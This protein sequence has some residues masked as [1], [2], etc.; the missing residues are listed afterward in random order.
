MAATDTPAAKPSLAV[1]FPF[2]TQDGKEFSDLEKLLTDL[3]QQSGGYYLLG[4]NNCWHGGIHITDEKFDYHKKTHPV[5][6]IMD[7]SVIAYRLNKNYPTQK[8]QA[9]STLPATDLKFSN[10]FCL[11]KH[12]YESPANQT[13][14]EHKSKTNKLT[15]YSLYM[16]L[17]D[18]NT[19][20]SET[21]NTDKTI[22]ITKNTQAR[23]TANI[24]HVI[25]VLKSGSTLKVDTQQQAYQA[26][27][28]GQSYNYYKGTVESKATGS[29]ESVVVGATVYLYSGCFPAGTFTTPEKT[30]SPGYWKA[31]VTGKSKERMKVYR[32]EQACKNRTTPH[33][34]LLNEQQTV[35]FESDQVK[36]ATINGE[37]H[38]IAPCTIANTATF[39]HDIRLDEGW[40]IVDESQVSWEKI[41]PT[42]FDNIVKLSEP[43][44]ISA[45]DPV[46][47]MG[48]WESPVDPIAAGTTKIKYQMHIELFTTDDKTALDK[49]LNNDAKLTTGKKYLKVPKSSMLYSSDGH[50]SF[51]NPH[52][53]LNAARDYVFE[54]SACTQVKD[55]AGTVFYNIKGIRTGEAAI[56][57]IDTAHVKI[58][59]NVKLVT[60]YDWKELGFSTLEETDNDSDGY[61]D[62]DKIPSTLFKDIFKRVD[63]INSR[64][65]QGDGNL[66][67]KEIQNA[68]QQDKDLRND[69]Y[70]IIAGHPSEWHSTT[71][72]NIKKL[73]EDFK[74]QNTEE[75]YKNFNQFEVDRF[76]QCEFVSQIDGLTQKLWHFHPLMVLTELNNCQSWITKE[77]LKLIAPN[78]TSANCSF[79]IDAINDLP[80]KFELKNIMS[81]SH[82]LAQML[83]ESAS[84]QYKKEL[85]RANNLP[86]YYPYIGRGALQITY[87][88]N[89][90]SYGDFIGDTFV[91][92]EVNMEKL[93]NE[94]HYIN[95]AGWYWCEFK[96]ITQYSDNDDFIMCTALVNGGFNHFDDRLNYL[97][98]AI[99]VL[100]IESEATKNHSGEYMFSESEIYNRI[101]LAYGWGLWSD[102]SS[103]K[104]GKE[105]NAADAK[106]GYERFIELCNNGYVES[107]PIKKKFYG[108]TFSQAKLFAEQRIEEL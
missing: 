102:P 31:K 47:F 52:A 58:E 80:N 28:Q 77:Q 8:W 45:G 32:T 20:V 29:A 73:F 48:I 81:R 91:G 64:N 100:G 2:L 27:V 1:K 75:E 6:C 88:D 108:K 55:T 7:G 11:I 4:A 13:E 85:T 46:G 62:P 70:K 93:E 63:G 56:G 25:G 21:A 42:E 76:L 40:M 97:N 69:L 59:G 16:H 74:A 60:Q 23:D 14:G 54:E 66:T 19:Y 5:R 92:S 65:G 12:E 68:L 39:A 72:N 49:F 61:I 86:D 84:F 96:N 17:A 35:T 44:P 57:P 26:S 34:A 22:A 36:S 30:I 105:K 98:N 18:Y 79:Y 95:A 103:N 107:S 99:R 104:I 24:N 9:K 50:G 78:M 15:F 37:T 10:G 83:H 67:G 41:E 101:K 33:D 87:F 3:S 43:L 90:K 106:A 71:Q 53:L 51:V 94:P 82:L 89:Y 38:K